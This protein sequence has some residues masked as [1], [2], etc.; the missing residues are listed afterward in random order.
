[1]SLYSQTPAS[2]VHVSLSMA[3]FVELHIFHFR[4]HGEKLSRNPGR[5]QRKV[6]I[7]TIFD[8]P[9]KTDPHEPLKRRHEPYH[10]KYRDE[11][12]FDKSKEILD[13]NKL[14]K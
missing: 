2:G 14:I 3:C 4:Y 13:L 12:K 1:M 7:S 10:L 11:V 6:V 5:A 8:D 9:A